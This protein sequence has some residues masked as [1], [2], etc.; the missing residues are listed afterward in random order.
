MPRVI[1]SE[2]VFVM[3]GLF[4]EN[5]FLLPHS[6]GDRLEDSTWTNGQ[7]SLDFF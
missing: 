6:H 7:G 4:L 3:Y 2:K 1:F 5:E